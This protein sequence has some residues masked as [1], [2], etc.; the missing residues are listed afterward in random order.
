MN[1]SLSDKLSN[2][3]QERRWTKTYVAGK[4]GKTLATYANYEY[5]IREPNIET[6]NKIAS[7]YNVSI[8]YLLGRSENP[9]KATLTDKE[10]IEAVEISDL[11]H[12][13][14]ELPN[15]PTE[16]LAKLKVIWELIKSENKSP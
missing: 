12:F 5:G 13:I 15:F 6:L 9:V 4:L 3:R 16:D 8:D 2:L 10:Y 1:N 11:Q 7:L 14:S